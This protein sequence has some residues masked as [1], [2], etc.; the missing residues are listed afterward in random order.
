MFPWWVQWAP[1]YYFPFSGSVAQRIEPDTDWFFGNIDAG[2]GDG[3]IEQ[4]AFDVASYGRQLGLLTEV[5]LDLAKQLPPQDVQA[6]ASLKRLQA[7]KT[8]I[9]LL[10]HQ[11]SADASER[12][13]KD[14]HYLRDQH[15]AAY[16]Q[17]RGRL[18]ELLDDA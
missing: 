10:K 18:R 7:I 4:K 13:I 6:N 3:R 1:Q 9:D 8:Q 2:A 12:V 14:L 17:L 16:A 11:E 15:P 5:L